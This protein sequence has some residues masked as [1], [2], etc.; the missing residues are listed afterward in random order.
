MSIVK[1]GNTN[2]LLEFN[3]AHNLN[4]QDDWNGGH[5]SSWEPI[6]NPEKYRFYLVSDSEIHE[7]LVSIRD[8]TG[9]DYDMGHEYRWKSPRVFLQINNWFGN[10]ELNS[11][12]LPKNVH[13]M[14]KEK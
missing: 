1:V 11:L 5:W 13:L 8:I 2:E 14:Y 6:R 12:D 7:V 4:W 3:D 10:I 9:V